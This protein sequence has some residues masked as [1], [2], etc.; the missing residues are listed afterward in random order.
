M[1]FSPLFSCP[2][3]SSLI[4]LV[5]IRSSFQHKPCQLG[6]NLGIKKSCKFKVLDLGKPGGVEIFIKLRHGKCSKMG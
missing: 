3:G 5:D 2:D 6:I 1:V 4:M